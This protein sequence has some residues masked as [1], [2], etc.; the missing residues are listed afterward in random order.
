MFFYSESAVLFER[1]IQIVT[2]GLIMHLDAENAS[3]YPGS[4]TTWE[5]LTANNNDGTLYNGTSFITTQYNQKAFNFDGINDYIQLPT[6]FFSQN[7]ND[8]FSLSVWFM[9]NSGK[10]TILGQQNNEPPGNGSGWVEAIYIDNYGKVRTS[11]FWGG[12]TTP[13]QTTNILNDGLWHNITVTYEN[14]SRKTYVDGILDNTWA[15]S[16]NSYSDNYY[17]FIGGGKSSG[18]TDSV[19]DYF[20]GSISNF[21]FYNKKLTDEEVTQNYNALKSRHIGTSTYTSGSS[22][23]ITPSVS[24]G[25]ETSEGWY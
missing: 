7:N 20:S 14:N 3:S 23:F 8:P 24:D 13:P 25:F 6:N 12:N 21:L 17:Y 16:Q 4:G 11:C 15:V 9:S 5:D 2:D 1:E 19:A 18:W 22:T 10:G